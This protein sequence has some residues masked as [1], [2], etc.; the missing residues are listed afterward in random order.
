MQ[1]S[2]HHYISVVTDERGSHS[3]L[4][5]IVNHNTSNPKIKALHR[6]ALAFNMTPPEFLKF[7]ALNEYSFDDDKDLD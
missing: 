4:D 7:A 5:N 3:T 1:F 2:G 6:L